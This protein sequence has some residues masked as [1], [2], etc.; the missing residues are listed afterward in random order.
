MKTHE[1][2]HIHLKLK[3]HEPGILQ[4]QNMSGA[5]VAQR[6]ETHILRTIYFSVNC[7]CFEIIKQKAT[8]IIFRK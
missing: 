4:V 6:N 1:Q 2:F 5:K 3:L 8:S 7:I